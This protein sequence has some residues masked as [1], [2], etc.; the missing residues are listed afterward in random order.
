MLGPKWEVVEAGPGV[1][2]NTGEDELAACCAACGIGVDKKVVAFCRFNSK[3][4]AGRV[5]CRTCQV[6]AAA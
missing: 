1:S 2:I 6:A 4:F 5:L 3:R